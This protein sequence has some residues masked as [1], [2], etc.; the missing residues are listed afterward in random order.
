MSEHDSGDNKDDDEQPALSAAKAVSPPAEGA[1]NLGFLRDDALLMVTFFGGY[2]YQSEG[3]PDSWAQAVLAAKNGDPKA[4]VLTAMREVD[5]PPGVC[6]HQDRTCELVKLFPYH[7]ISLY[8]EM[9][10]GFSAR[11]CSVRHGSR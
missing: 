4:V 5:Q 10:A 2:D 6:H 8:P 7:M 1:Q 9:G 3:D 11:S